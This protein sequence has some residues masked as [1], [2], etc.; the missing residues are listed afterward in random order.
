M[1]SR[2][3]L[4]FFIQQSICSLSIHTCMHC[5]NYNAINDDNTYVCTYLCQ[6][7]DLGYY[8]NEKSA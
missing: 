5:A 1:G 2:V 4:H 7:G 3:P 6:S 8:I